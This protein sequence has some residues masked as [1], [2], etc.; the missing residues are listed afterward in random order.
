MFIIHI[1]KEKVLNFNNVTFDEWT[2]TVT[3]MSVT[4]Y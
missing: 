3:H 4:F 2:N 1:K